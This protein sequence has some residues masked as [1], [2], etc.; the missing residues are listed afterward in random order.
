[1][2]KAGRHTTLALL[3]EKARWVRR[4]T[5]AL[6]GLA[7]GTR[8]ASSLSCIEILVALYYGGILKFNPKEPFWEKRDRLIISKGHGSIAMYP[9]LADL[10]FFD[11]AELGRICKPGSF[12]RVIPDPAVPGYETVNGSLGLGLGVGCGIALALKAKQ[13][14][15]QVFVLSGDG[16]LNEGAVW[17]AVMCA[18]QHRLDNLLM[19]VDRNKMCMLGRCAQIID[20]EPLEEKFSVFGWD[21]LRIDGH[22]M[23]QVYTS[24]KAV[25]SVRNNRPRV[26]IADTLKGKGVACLEQDPLCHVRMLSAEEVKAALEVL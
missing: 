9:L 11:K 1:M 4:E 7:P 3:K 6:H 14:S 5:V 20:L 22:N 8:L 13:L 10:G 25:A 17:E 16:E 12:L 26:I 21:T 23:Q 15:N 2:K 24:I 19:I 18:A